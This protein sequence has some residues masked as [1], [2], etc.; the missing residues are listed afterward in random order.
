MPAAFAG[1]ALWRWPLAGQRH[2]KTATNDAAAIHFLS[3][4]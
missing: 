2:N 3:A 1:G 4:I